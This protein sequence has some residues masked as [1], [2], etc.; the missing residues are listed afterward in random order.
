[1]HE[2]AP[3]L[4]AVLGPGGDSNAG[5][6]RDPRGTVVID[7][8][9]NEPLAA[10]L[11]AAVRAAVPGPIRTLVNT[12]VHGDHV[13]GNPAFPADTQILAHSRC[14][15]A[16]AEA[17]RAAG[18]GEG[19]P[20]PES[21]VMALTFGANLTDLVPE[22][23]ATGRAFF[24]WRYEAGGLAGA[25]LRLPTV[26]VE[27]ECTLHLAGRR[28]ILRHLGPGHS[29]SD[30]IAWFP[31]DG[32]V[33]VADLVFHGRFPWLGDSDVAAWIARL[34]EVAGLGAC[35]V[36]PGHGDPVTPAEVLA[37][38]DLL[39]AVQG[40]AAAAAQTGLGEAEAVAAAR[41]PA[42]AGLP[43]YREWFPIAVRK[44]FRE[45]RRATASKA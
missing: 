23:D 8:M 24:R 17:L 9:Q 2:L 13:F 28:L 21:I 16:M 10:R 27:R 43:R 26:T 36:V 29:E 20:L 42:Y 12:H 35:V 34:E 39:R 22:E 11:L 3:G 1:V 44:L 15:A 25:R 5:F 40:A 41:L 32:V 18:V 14:R 31:D 45:R 19:A 4:W 38:R 37:F 6:V 33:F 7:A 30:L